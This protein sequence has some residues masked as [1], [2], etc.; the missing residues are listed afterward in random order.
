MFIFSY[1]EAHKVQQ[2]CNAMQKEQKDAWINARNIKIEAAMNKLRQKQD[3]ELGAL[4]KK[5]KTGQDEQL[6][7]RGIEEGRLK[8]K[9]ANACK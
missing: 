2:R 3:T 7:D 1:V 5:I 6:K 4:Q 8:L 9:Y